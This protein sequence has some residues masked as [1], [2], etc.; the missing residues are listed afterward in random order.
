MYK[1][2]AFYQLPLRA[3]NL[4]GYDRGDNFTSGAGGYVKHSVPCHAGSSSIYIDNFGNIY[5]CISHQ[6]HRQLPSSI[7]INNLAQTSY[8]KNLRIAST[9][10]CYEP[11]KNDICRLYCPIF[12]SNVSRFVGSLK[13]KNKD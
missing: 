5:P 4:F 13:D 9:T 7:C 8:L 1:N 2:Q 12:L 11:N 6:V 3:H 10:P